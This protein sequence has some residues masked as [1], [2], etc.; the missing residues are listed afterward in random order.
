MKGSIVNINNKGE[1]NMKTIKDAHESLKGDLNN[2]F[3]YGGGNKTVSYSH[4]QQ[5]YFMSE[6]TTSNPSYQY[7]CT[8]DEFNNYAYVP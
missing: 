1:N 4:S 2:A 6:S 5:T 3:M 7:V 8:V